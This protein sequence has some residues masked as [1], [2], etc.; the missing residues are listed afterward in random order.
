LC[1]LTGVQRDRLWHG[2]SCQSTLGCDEAT[3]GERGNLIGEPSC[4]RGCQRLLVVG[5]SLSRKVL[6]SQSDVEFS[7]RDRLPA[8]EAFAAKNCVIL[9]RMR[10]RETTSPNR[11]STE[12]GDAMSL[13][14]GKAMVVCTA[15]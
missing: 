10:W 13:P 4:D 6:K 1:A 8:G 12:P 11:K 5:G 9:V 7:H 2:G 14:R 3:S 15:E